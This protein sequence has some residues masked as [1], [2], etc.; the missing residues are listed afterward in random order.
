MTTETLRYT[1]GN[2]YAFTRILYRLKG[3]DVVRKSGLFDPKQ[4]DFV[5]ID[6]V[7]LNCERQE[8]VHWE[9]DDKEEKK[10]DGFIFRQ[11]GGENDGRV[12][13]NQYPVAHFGQLDDSANYRAKPART[14]QRIAELETL[15][16]ENEKSYLQELISS[17]EDAFTLLGKLIGATSDL[18]ARQVN[19]YWSPEEKEIMEN[20]TEALKAGI[21]ALIGKQLGYREAL[22]TFTNG[23]PP[24]RLAGFLE[25]YIIEEAKAA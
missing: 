8:R 14:D 17:Y 18:S 15:K 4:H 6:L 25:P 11:V 16:Q 21:E 9:F 13:H 3:D 5:A 23:K 22:I 19:G 2:S 20:V 24:E 1:P 7:L 10:Y 12:F